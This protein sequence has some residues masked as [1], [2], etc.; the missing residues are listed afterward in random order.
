[1]DLRGEGEMK[2]LVSLHNITKD[3]DIEALAE[4]VLQEL[5]E[6]DT[7]SEKASVADTPED[8]P[9]GDPDDED[10]E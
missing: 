8:N 9:S 7:D 2:K 10:S 5:G 6:F 4:V 3:T 1:V